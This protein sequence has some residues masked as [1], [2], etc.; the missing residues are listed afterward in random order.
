MNSPEEI[1]DALT[2][3]NKALLAAAFTEEGQA[4]MNLLAAAMSHS[5][6]GWVLMEATP[7][8]CL[9]IFERYRPAKDRN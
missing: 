4:C 8:Q 2:D 6:A 9:E 3:G 7:E 1:A 5:L